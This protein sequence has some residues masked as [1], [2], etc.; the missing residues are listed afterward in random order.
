MKKSVI[1]NALFFLLVTLLFSSCNP[2][3]NFFPDPNNPGLSRFTSRS[4]DIMTTYINDTA[5]INPYQPYLL[6][7]DYAPSYIGNSPMFIYKQNTMSALDTLVLSWQME[8]SDSA[9][10]NYAPYECL[11][12]LMPVPKLFSMYNFLNWDGFRFPYGSTTVTLQ[13]QGNNLFAGNNNIY[14]GNGNIYFVEMNYAGSATTPYTYDLSGL[15]QGNLVDS[16]G[17]AV[18]VTKGRFDFSV[19]L[20]IANFSN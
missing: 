18:F 16:V 2:P 15:F 3:R 19:D 10:P 4:Y 20:S 12:I 9:N 1:K 17:N 13:L 7:A 5:Y 6:F 11:S 8:Y 14:T